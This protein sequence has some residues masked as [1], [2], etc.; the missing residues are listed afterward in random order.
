MSS[1][2]KFLLEG[3][4]IE[5]QGKQH[6]K[7]ESGAIFKAGNRREQAW[8]WGRAHVQNAELGCLTLS[9]ARES[10]DSLDI[11]A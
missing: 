9:L 5:E 8:L 10:E 11:K 1:S 3:S 6:G 2:F 7:K 4:H